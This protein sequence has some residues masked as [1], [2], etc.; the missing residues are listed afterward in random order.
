LGED[1]RTCGE[2]TLGESS[3]SPEPEVGPTTEGSP[4]IPEASSSP[5]PELPEEPITVQQTTT[6]T[7]TAMPPTPDLPPPLEVTPASPQELPPPA[8][9]VTASPQEQSP[10][11]PGQETLP[12]LET[13]T[14]TTTTTTETPHVAG[15][16]LPDGTE[17]RTE[18]AAHEHIPGT[19]ITP[20]VNLEL[21][22]TTTRSPVTPDGHGYLSPAVT[23]GQQPMSEQGSGSVESV[24]ANPLINTTTPVVRTDEVHQPTL[25]G[26]PSRENPEEEDGITIL[27]LPSAE[28][29]TNSSPESEQVS[30]NAAQA[31]KASRAM[32]SEEGGSSDTEMVPTGSPPRP[33]SHSDEFMVYSDMGLANRNTTTTSTTR[34]QSQSEEVSSVEDS[35]E[36]HSGEPRRSEQLIHGGAEMIPVDNDLERERE[37]V[38]TIQP[39]SLINDTLINEMIENATEDVNSE[40]VP[41]GASSSQEGS[42]EG[43]VVEANQSEESQSSVE[44]TPRAQPE[45]SPTTPAPSMDQSEPV[46][47]ERRPGDDILDTLV[48]EIQAESGTLSPSQAEPSVQE[49]S[50]N[51]SVPA[52]EESGG[53]NETRPLSE[54]ELSS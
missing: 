12:V 18:A 26:I 13:T 47:E 52:E 22:T 37:E 4:S 51:A 8:E 41:K 40:H 31:Q 44:E 27:P 50:N 42:S 17:A 6:T 24:D 43:V 11:S 7:T 30:Q 5:P 49:S 48:H 38:T 29:E 46:G 25:S 15:D 39:I 54:N 23:E 53:A 45:V 2:V 16:T 20:M 32:G 33:L 14:T 36:I 34:P 21:I 9:P 10:T 3:A 1:K 19:T 35:R 28:A